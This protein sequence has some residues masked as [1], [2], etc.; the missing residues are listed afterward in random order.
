VVQ[1]SIQDG[2]RHDL[3]AEH[4]APVTDGSVG[5]DQN[6]SPFVAAADELEQQMRGRRLER[7]IA[8]LVHDQQFGLGQLG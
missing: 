3:I 1:Q 2:G 8:E 5:R 4:C 6:A 7:Q